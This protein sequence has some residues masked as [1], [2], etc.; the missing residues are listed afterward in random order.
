MKTV[1]FNFLPY[2]S[3][4]HGGAEV[5]FTNV[6]LE[7]ARQNKCARIIFYINRERKGLF[8]KQCSNIEEEVIELPITGNRV[9]RII[10]EQIFLPVKCKQDGVDW[11]ISNYISPVFG[12]IKKVVIVHDMLFKRYPSLFERSKLLY[13]KT[14]LPMSMKKSDLIGTVSNFSANEI[15]TFFPRF[16]NKLFVT[17]EGIRSSLLNPDSHNA[18]D[19]VKVSPY[20]L[21]V[22][23][24]GAHKNLLSLIEAFKYIAQKNPDISLLFTGEPKTPDAIA[25]KSKVMCLVDNYKLNDRVRFVGYVDDDQF[26]T[27]Y[28][29]ATLTVMPSLYEGFGLPIIESQYFNT[30]VACSNCASMPEV[31]GEAGVLF[32]PHDPLNIADNIINLITNPQNMRSLSEKCKINI[33]RYTW[34]KAGEKLTSA[35]KKHDI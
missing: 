11:L 35:I 7:F 33:D 23:T 16:K 34:E 4:G 13:W 1:A 12:S 3:K 5:Y 27:L 22:G 19:N 15:S 26:A 29:N 30:P 2:T 17:P 25:Y 31:V 18:D 10:S 20:L 28:S 9:S 8:D 14:L 32:D 6:A 21:C 24:F